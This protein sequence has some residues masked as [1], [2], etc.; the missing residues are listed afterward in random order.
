MWSVECKTW[1]CE[2]RLS[3]EL[4]CM[5]RCGGLGVGGFTEKIYYLRYGGGFIRGGIVSRVDCL[6]RIGG[7]CNHFV[8]NGTVSASA[9][10]VHTINGSL[11]S[12]FNRSPDALP[13]SHL[14]IRDNGNPKTSFT[15]LLFILPGWQKYCVVPG[16]ACCASRS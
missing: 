9:W 5:W 6:V 3:G 10:S 16:V 2:R 12:T 13:E 14:I 7:E 15:L 11:S 4:T 1:L 8:R